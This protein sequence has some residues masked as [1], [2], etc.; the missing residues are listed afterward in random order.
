MAIDFALT[1]G[2]KKLQKTARE[3]AKEVLDP[4]VG[5]ADQEPDPQKAF[6]MMKAPWVEA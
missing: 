6:A 5:D 2:Q 1:D 3:F 4:V